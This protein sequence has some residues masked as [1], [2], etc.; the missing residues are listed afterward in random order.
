MASLDGLTAGQSN[1]IVFTSADGIEKFTILES[2]TAK[3][4]APISKEIAMDGTTRHPQFH[5]GWSGTAIF[6]RGDHFLDDYIAAK[7]RNYY[8]SG[9]QIDLTITQSI[10]E[11]DGTVTQYQF[12]GVVL[13]LEDGGNYS[14]TEIVKQSISFMAKRRLKLA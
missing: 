8:L 7:E 9:D 3:E 10:S 14:G 13:T 2:F 11:L 4:D 5:Q 1:K 6:E 12:T